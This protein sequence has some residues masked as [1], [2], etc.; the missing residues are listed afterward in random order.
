MCGTACFSGVAGFKTMAFVIKQFLP[1]KITII[2]RE[3]EAGTV[4]VER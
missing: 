4:T 3:G 2:G 1:I